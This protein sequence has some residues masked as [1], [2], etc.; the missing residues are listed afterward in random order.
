MKKILYLIVILFL[1]Y[2]CAFAGETKIH[3][4]TL[5]SWYS[6]ANLAFRNGDIVRAYKY[7]SALELANWGA[8]DKRYNEVRNFIHK[9][10][11][12]CERKLDRALRTTG[13]VKREDAVGKGDSPK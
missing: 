10:L 5:S 9:R 8:G 6:E 7:Y 2:Q 11:R 13:L 3:S 12:E 4:N 1:S